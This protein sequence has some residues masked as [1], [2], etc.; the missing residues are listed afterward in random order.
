VKPHFGSGL[1][2]RGARVIV[3]IGAAAVCLL[4]LGAR[5]Q[6]AGGLEFA[7]GTSVVVEFA[8]GSSTAF[9]TVT[10]IDRGAATA[11][12]FSAI[13]EDEDGQD[14]S[15]SVSIAPDPGVLAQGSVTRVRLTIT[16]S[17]P[18]TTAFGHIVATPSIGGQAAVAPMETGPPV[19]RTFQPEMIAFAAGIIAI[20]FVLIRAIF[21]G[22]G[23]D[24][25]FSLSDTMGKPGWSFSESWASTLTVALAIAGTVAASTV[26]PPEPLRLST[27]GYVGLNL[28]FGGLTVFAPLVYVAFRSHHHVD[29]PTKHSSTH[30]Y[31]G[32]FLAAATVT[33]WA[34]FGQLFTLAVAADEIAVR[35]NLKSF[36]RWGVVGAVVVAGYLVVRYAWTSIPWTISDQKVEVFETIDGVTTQIE[37]PPRSWSLL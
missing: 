35:Y 1:A 5:A 14:V 8:G 29:D 24:E 32:G 18:G 20:A 10:L 34:V 6:V 31:V 17:S 12:A 30:G 33:V 37:D 7:E 36:A 28:F 26:L 22:W 16:S 27:V 23:T 3:I 15:A 2:R 4:P 13:L 21:L 19:S 25:S 9:A 11:V